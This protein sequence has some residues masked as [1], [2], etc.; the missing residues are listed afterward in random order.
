VCMD[1]FWDLIFQL[2][3]HGTDTLHLAFIF[4][5]SVSRNNLFQKFSIFL[6]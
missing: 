5:F 2:M 1:N 6:F 3:K 4:L